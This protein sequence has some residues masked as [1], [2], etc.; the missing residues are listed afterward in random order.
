VVNAVDADGRFAAN[1]VARRLVQAGLAL[2]ELGRN[3]SDCTKATCRM[4]SKCSGFAINLIGIH[5]VSGC[6]ALCAP[7]LVTGGAPG[8]ICLGFCFTVII[9]DAILAAKLGAECIKAFR[10]RQCI[11]NS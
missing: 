8:V 9:A 3:F 6:I 1:F 10:D 7:S 2:C 4:L 5:Y 11:C